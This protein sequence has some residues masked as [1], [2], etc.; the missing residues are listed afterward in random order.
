MG[1]AH[2]ASQPAISPAPAMPTAVHVE[3]KCQ[4]TRPCAAHLLVIALAGG[5]RLLRL[6]ILHITQVLQIRQERL[7][8]RRHGCGQAGWWLASAAP[9]LGWRGVT[10]SSQVQLLVPA[11]QE[12]HTLQLGS[13]QAAASGGEQRRQR[14]GGAAPCSALRS[15]EVRPPHALSVAQARSGS[16]GAATTCQRLQAKLAGRP[17]YPSYQRELMVRR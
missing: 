7:R 9:G 16:A 11:P 5:P 1:V 4:P 2:T 6:L 14:Q 10:G 3:A 8:Q 13:G 17:A 12:K 15:A